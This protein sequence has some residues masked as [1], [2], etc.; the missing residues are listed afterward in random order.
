MKPTQP[1]QLHEVI[2]QMRRN[3]RKSENRKLNLLKERLL[4]TTKLL[5]RAS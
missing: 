3:E 5:K 2:L 1:I 4:K